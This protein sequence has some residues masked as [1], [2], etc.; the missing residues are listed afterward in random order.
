LEKLGVELEPMHPGTRD[1]FLAPY[2][3]VEVPDSET[4]ERIVTHLRQSG[5]I[6]AAYIKP[7]DELP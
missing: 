6:E 1:P 5:A 4:A 3:I 7:L 2:F